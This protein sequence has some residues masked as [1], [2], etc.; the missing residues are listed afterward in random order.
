MGSPAPCGQ[1][2]SAA[3]WEEGGEAQA[4]QPRRPVVTG[5]AAGADPPQDP[6]GAGATVSCPHGTG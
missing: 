1:E 2:A 6:A 3:M 4:P 5:K